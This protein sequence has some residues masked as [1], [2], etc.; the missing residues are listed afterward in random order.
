[1]YTPSGNVR[2]HRN[3]LDTC[4]VHSKPLDLASQNARNQVPYRLYRPQVVSTNLLGSP[5]LH[6]H[7][8]SSFILVQG[9]L[10]SGTSVKSEG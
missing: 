6:T 2:L 9:L 7:T 8:R 4:V 5:L 3:G 10:N 1:M